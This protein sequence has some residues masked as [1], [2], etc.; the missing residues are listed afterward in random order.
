MSSWPGSSSA[1]ITSPERLRPASGRF[2]TTLP[3]AVP[4]STMTTVAELV[5]AALVETEAEILT[6]G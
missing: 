1:G 4:A 2:S 5:D 3:P 6:D